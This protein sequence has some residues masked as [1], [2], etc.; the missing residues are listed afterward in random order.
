MVDLTPRNKSST[1]VA[2]NIRG[3]VVGSIILGKE[4]GTR[5]FLWRKGKVVPLDVPGGAYTTAAAVNGAGAVVG[6]YVKD[7][8]ERGVIWRNGQAVDLGTLPAAQWRHESPQHV[9][10]TAIND[11]GEV[12]GIVHGDY[13]GSEWFI[14]RKGVMATFATSPNSAEES[15]VAINRNGQVLVQVSGRRGT[16]RAWLYDDDKLIPLPTLGGP[17]TGGAGLNNKGWIAGMSQPMPNRYRPFVW[18]SGR[19]IALD[20]PARRY[21]PP[22]PSVS[23]I[24]NRGQIVGY[25]YTERGQHILVWNR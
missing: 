3:D 8:Q 1:A 7:G 25:D 17:S 6:T 24:N 9:V 18:R 13:A 5:A 11:R 10:P 4:R 2:V 19:M 14:W 21:A 12:V 15:A 20:T 16:S 23:A 22:W